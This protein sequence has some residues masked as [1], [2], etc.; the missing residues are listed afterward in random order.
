MTTY[1]SDRRI[2]RRHLVKTGLRIRLWNSP[3]AGQKTESENLSDRG[4]FFATDEPLVIGS[5]LQI[6]LQMPEEI[7][8]KPTTL[9]RCTGHVVRLAPADSPGGKSGVGV[10]FDC[11]EIMGLETAMVT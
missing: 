2:S 10:Q 1:E 9:W 8:G 7:T 6:L 4:T 5:A 11:Y 3:A